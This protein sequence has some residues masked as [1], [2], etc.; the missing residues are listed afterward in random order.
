MTK[1][2]APTPYYHKGVMK[3]KTYEIYYNSDFSLA[4]YVY[5]RRQNVSSPPRRYPFN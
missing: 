2:I 4:S 3:S 1:K 5:P